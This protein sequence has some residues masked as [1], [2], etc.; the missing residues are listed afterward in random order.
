MCKGLNATLARETAFSLAHYNTYRFL[1]D[2]F[3]MSTFNVD[4]TFIPAFLAGAFAITLSQPL[5]VIRSKVSLNSQISMSD[6]A[7]RI[8]AGQGWRGFFIGFI[9]RF[10]RKPIN[11][12]ICWT[13]IE[14][15]K[16]YWALRKNPHLL[17]L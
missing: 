2:D 5:E 15:I 8:W 11:S 14:S 10:C 1:K 7:K 12:G 9:P 6:C 16:E 3:F 17:T 4:S 13:V